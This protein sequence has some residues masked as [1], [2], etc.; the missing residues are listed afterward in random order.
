MDTSIISNTSSIRLLVPPYQSPPG[1]NGKDENRDIKK[2][3]LSFF[4]PKSKLFYTYRKEI[5]F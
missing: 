3:P 2:I 1:P 5:L 4:R